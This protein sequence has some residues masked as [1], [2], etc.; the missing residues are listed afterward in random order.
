M[1]ES[2]VLPLVLRSFALLLI[3]VALS[4]P[5]QV[6]AQPNSGFEPFS[7]TLPIFRITLEGDTV[8][9]EP[10]IAG[11]LEVINQPGAPN[12]SNST[13]VA[14]SVRIGI[15]LRGRSSLNSDKKS[16]GFETWDAGNEDVD[17]SLLGFPEESD[18]VL[19]GPYTDKTLVRNA[20]AYRTAR[21][22]SE[23]APRS[24]FLELIVNGDYRGL[25]LLVE[26]VK[27][28]RN[29]VDI[30]KL[31]PE[32]T[33][34]DD[35]TGGYIFENSLE[36]PEPGTG[37]SGQPSG[38]I[39]SYQTG[40]YNFVYPKARDIQPEQ[41]AYVAGWMAE[42]EDAL[43]EE[44]FAD[45]ELGYPAYVDVDSWRD[46]VLFQ[47]FGRDVDAYLG[48]TFFY[49]D[50]DS[51]GGRLHAGPVWDLNL[52]FGNDDFC[53]DT[54]TDGFAIERNGVCDPKLR[55]L[56]WTRVWEDSTFQNQVAER[57]QSLRRGPLSDEAI[58]ARFDSLVTL[59]DGSGARERNFDRWM[60]VE[61]VY[62]WPNPFVGVTH[63]ED[64]AYMRRWLISRAAWLD[65]ALPAKAGEFGEEDPGGDPADQPSA[66]TELTATLKL[67][68]NPTAAGQWVTLDLP[69]GV[70]DGVRV[71]VRSTT[72]QLLAGYT[73]NASELRVRFRVA[74]PGL[75]LV[76]VQ[77]D[78]GTRR[79]TRRLVVR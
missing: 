25:Y 44:T 66:T 21:T 67:Y 52:A 34:G 78:A 5:R 35:L 62:R 74:S 77:G 1:S 10:K 40:Q 72:G 64:A 33:G 4:E 13:D 65:G 43:A 41:A 61:G 49:K 79:S 53:G 20:F 26:R 56:I 27:R 42:F 22:F 59:I 16:F 17:V 39:G 37:W 75:Y 11:R 50:K 48:S 23:F 69:E 71:R 29:R 36:K 30:S 54:L 45:P 24:Q 3:V 19:H 28:G 63:A 51:K 7:T 15:E 58:L 76:E 55:P 68:P 2:K 57:W 32:D 9:D 18:W 38:R 8:V 14:Q 12:A 47:E 60:F 73:L 46:Y 70:S 31:K 6:L